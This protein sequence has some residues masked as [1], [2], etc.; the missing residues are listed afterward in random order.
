[1]LGLSVARGE[2]IAFLDADDLWHSEKLA[3][4]VGR[5]AARPELDLCII[6]VQNF[7]SPE[8]QDQVPGFAAHP[9]ARRYPGY[10]ASALCARKTCFSRIGGFNPALY[11]ADVKDWFVRA[12][13]HGAV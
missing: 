7:W 10:G 4:Q 12:A 11:H 8:L 1:N 5:C 3:R 6:S 2:F 9:L 13:E